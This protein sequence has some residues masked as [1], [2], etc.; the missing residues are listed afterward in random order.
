M[1]PPIAFA[2]DEDALAAVREGGPSSLLEAV[3]RLGARLETQ[4]D[5]EACLR[6]AVRDWQSE[7]FD[8]MAFDESVRRMGE[9]RGH[10]RIRLTTGAVPGEPLE[11]RQILETVHQVI[12]RCQRFLRWRNA[13]SSNP[14]FD[15]AL[16]LHERLHDRTKPLVV[17]D[18]EHALDTWRWTLRLDEQASLAVQV[19]AL[20]HDIE[21]LYAEPDVRIEHRAADYEAFKAAHAASGSELVAA[22]M[23]EIGMP[24]AIALRICE[25][26]ARHELGGEDGLGEACADLVRERALVNDADALSFF[27]L[28]ANGF[29]NYYGAEH[30]ARKVVYTWRRLSRQAR[31]ELGQV[32][33]AAPIRTFLDQAAG[34]AFLEQAGPFSDPPFTGALGG[35]REQVGP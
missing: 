34:G 27:S 25:L 17:A 22:F 32:K 15:R 6:L 23:V 3:G 4:I 11:G 7:R 2:L 8:L 10:C 31:R 26:V 14:L 12:T 29:L 35:L 20:F 5:D 19:A 18:Y 1:L 13:A 16:A 33:M 21:R 24:L 9:T 28:N 30:T